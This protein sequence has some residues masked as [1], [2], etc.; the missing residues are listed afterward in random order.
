M[1]ANRLTNLTNMARRTPIREALP[2][3]LHKVDLQVTEA[4]E[5]AA[6]QAGLSTRAVMVLSQIDSAEPKSQRELS[7]RIGV[8]QTL[9]VAAIDELERA[10]LVRRVR[11]PDDRRQHIVEITA[12]GASVLD[13]ADVRLSAI[14]RHVFAKLSSAERAQLRALLGK[15]L[16]LPV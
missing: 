15:V 5:A 7:E 13:T 16:G 2:V 1:A 12:A 10:A 3:M 4:M 6:T 9:L 14:E 8:D 11:N